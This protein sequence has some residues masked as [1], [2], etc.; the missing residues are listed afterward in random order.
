MDWPLAVVLCA[1]FVAVV[2]LTWVVLPYLRKRSDAETRLVALEKA[3]VEL[4]HAVAE[5]SQRLE[6]MGM[7]GLPRLG[8]SR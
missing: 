7:R 4:Q 3:N 8:V 6:A 5:Q 1:S 2:A